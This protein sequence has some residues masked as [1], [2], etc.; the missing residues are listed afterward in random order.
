MRYIA[1]LHL[2]SKYAYACSKKLSITELSKWGMIKGITLLATGDFTHPAWLAELKRDLEPVGNGLFKPTEEILTKAQQE[3]P[4]S[5]H[6]EI[7]FMLESEVSNIYSKH[8]KVRKIH[9]LLYAPSFEIVDAINAQLSDIG[10]LASDGR[11]ILGLDAKELLK[12]VINTAP[13]AYFVPA[14]AWTPHFA[15]FGSNSGFDS[16]EDCFEELTEHIFALETGLS[17]DPPMNRL[18]SDLDRFAL[19]SNSDSHSA[20]RI[21]REAN[22]FDTELSYDALWQAV[23]DK[24]TNKF[25]QTIEFFPH[26]GRYHYDG[27]RKCDT[28]LHPNESNNNDNLCPTCGKRMT[29]GVLH[30]VMSLADRQEAEK[31][32]SF[33]SMIP[34]DEIIAEVVQK[35]VKTKTV[36]K[37]YFNLIDQLG[38]EF[39][40]MLKSSLEDIEKA[41]SPL[42]AEAIR[43]VRVGN[44]AIDPGY[45]G[46]YGTVHVFED[47]ERE[48]FLQT[49]ANHEQQLSLM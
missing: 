13:D 39:T 34:L 1:D 37:E 45:D 28:C 33:V 3:V 26:E 5:C 9:N 41:S 8:D 10:N 16:I 6:S 43:K 14:H 38:P 49:Q 29:L 4:S 15:L 48:T 23:K 40:I 32:E 21:G 20:P 30:R 44:V 7:F 35:G 47:N 25:V 27:H 11:P 36:A 22:I 17:S 12:I 18:W 31:K 46:L 42:I 2:H 19:M 24:D